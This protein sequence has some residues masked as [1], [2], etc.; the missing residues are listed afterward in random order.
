MST[1]L[2]LHLTPALLQEITGS[3]TGTGGTGT[4]NGTWAYLWDNQPPADATISP[5]LPGA[6]TNF[7]PLITAGQL[8]SNVTLGADGDYDVVVNLTDSATPTVQSGTVYLIVQSEDP[9]SHHDLTTLIGGT[10][11]NIQPNVEAWN[12]GYAQFEFTLEKG[13]PIRVT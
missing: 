8:T 3:S 6:T 11:G 12:Y 4:Q 5:L 1:T 9:S 7:T 10:E 2:T 13:R